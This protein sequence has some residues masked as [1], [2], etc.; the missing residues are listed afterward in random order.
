MDANQFSSAVDKLN[1][2]VIEKIP[3]INEKMALDATAQ[4]KDRLVNDGQ[5]ADGSSLGS[6]STNEVPLFFRKNGKVIA[7]FRNA[8]NGGG[9]SLYEKVKKENQSRLKKNGGDG[10]KPRGI[11]YKEWREANNRPTDHV[12]LSFS[13]TTLRDIGVVKQVVSGARIITTVGAKNTKVRESGSTTEEI[14]SGLSERYGNFIEPNQTE[15][16]RMRDYL[17]NQIE[18]ILHDSFR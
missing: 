5:K 17:Q 8:L 9:E 11:S 12:T 13:G 6:Y 3:T 7:P 2:Q 15:I 14:I 18:Q 1:A 4:I 10:S 16:D